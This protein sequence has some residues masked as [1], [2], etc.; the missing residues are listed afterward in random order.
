MNATKNALLFLSW[1]P[2]NHSFT[3]NSQSL[4]ELKH[5]IHLTKAVYGI[6]HY[7]FHQF[8]LKFLFLFN[9]SMD[10]LTLNVII[11]FK[12]KI[13]ENPHTVLLPHLRFLSCK[14]KFQNSVVSAW[15]ELSRNW[16]GIKLFELIKLKFWVCHFFSIVTFKQI[17]N[18]PL[19]S[20]LFLLITNLFL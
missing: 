18:I 16:P 11:T 1:A 6:F 10:S 8:L 9:K 14:K 5:K 19:L 17:F 2:T 13:M 4:Y 15:V 3:F 12:I 7:R 20:N